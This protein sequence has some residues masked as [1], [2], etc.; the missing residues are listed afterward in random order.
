MLPRPARGA[1]LASSLVGFLSRDRGA[2]ETTPAH[3]PLRASLAHCLCTWLLHCLLYE[4]RGI[5]TWQRKMKRKQAPPWR[6]AH[7]SSKANLFG[8][9]R[10]PLSHSP[11]RRGRTSLH[12]ELNLIFLAILTIAARS[13]RDQ[14]NQLGAPNFSGAVATAPHQRAHQVS[15]PR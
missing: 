4:N 9:L 14:V 13:N 11:M 7:R 15:R 8:H 6:I 5:A 10:G 2:V 12:L 1:P 3:Q